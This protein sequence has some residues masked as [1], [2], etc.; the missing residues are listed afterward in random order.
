MFIHALLNMF[1]PLTKYY[2]YL[3]FIMCINVSQTIWYF[4]QILNIVYEWTY[5]TINF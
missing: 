4:K 3:S 1:E 2:K 5:P